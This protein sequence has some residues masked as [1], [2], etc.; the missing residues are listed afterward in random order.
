MWIGLLKIQSMIT[1]NCNDILLLAVNI[2]ENVK[3]AT[4]PQYWS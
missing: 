3:Y 1:P 4:E 2:K